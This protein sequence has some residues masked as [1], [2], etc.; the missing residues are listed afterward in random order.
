VL[1][2]DKDNDNLTMNEVE[3][4]VWRNGM[5]SMAQNPNA[6]VKISMLGFVMP[7]WIRTPERLA[8]MK[9]LVLEMV[10]PFGPSKCM[11]A[12]I[13]WN[14]AVVSDADGM[15]DIA[16]EPVQFLELIYGFLNDTYS[17]E[18]LDC[19]FCRNAIKFYGVS[20]YKQE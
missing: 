3:L 15:S 1:G 16:P 12:T 17:E 20:E 14:N 7:G 6:Y 2:A 19:L 5:K 18:E 4:N 10:K 9:L 11:V 8:L 13:F